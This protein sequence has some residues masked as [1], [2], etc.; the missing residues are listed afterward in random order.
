MNAPLCFVGL[1]NPGPQYSWTR[2]NIGLLALEDIA[3]EQHASM[4]VHKRSNTLV[5]TTQIS[6]RQVILVNPRSAMNLSG[7]KVQAI[8]QFYKVAPQ[9]LVVFHDDMEVPFGEVRWRPGGGDRGHNGLKSISQACKTKDYVRLSLGIGR[10]PGSMP[11]NKFV[12]QRFRQ[13]ERA[14]LPII[15][16]QALE[17]CRAAISGG[18]V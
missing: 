16:G 9:Q 2:H 14:E 11:P 13:Q 3:N 8:T 18:L 5:A 1:G 17:Q 7:P 10:P 12:L 15:F 6:G 4:Q